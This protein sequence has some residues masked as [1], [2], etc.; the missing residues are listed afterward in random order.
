MEPMAKQEKEPS[1]Q[2]GAVLRERVCDSPG[3][4]V[5]RAP[6]T[7]AAKDPASDREGP[8]RCR[9]YGRPLP[10][11]RVRLR[12]GI[13]VEKSI[14]DRFRA[15]GADRNIELDP[16]RRTLPHGARVQ[17]CRFR[18]RAPYRGDGVSSSASRASLR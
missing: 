3:D 9:A 10:A 15:S 13:S 11:L 2:S 8:L 5:S 7:S 12:D 4:A 14:S 1:F 6:K 16:A 18:S 17:L